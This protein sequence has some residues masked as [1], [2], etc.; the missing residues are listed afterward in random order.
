[1]ATKPRGGITHSL[2]GCA[3]ARLRGA[4]RWLVVAAAVSTAGAAGTMGDAAG[5]PG[6]TR[7]L[8]STSTSWTLLGCHDVAGV[9]DTGAGYATQ[10]GG[11]VQLSPFPAAAH[12]VCAY[13]YSNITD[14]W[15]MQ[16]SPA[17]T[18]RGDS[19][20]GPQS[21]CA[22]Y[23]D[24]G[25]GHRGTAS[26]GADVWPLSSGAD[27][28]YRITGAAGDGLLLSPPVGSSGQVGACGSASGGWLTSLTPAEADALSLGEAASCA[29]G[30]FPA[31]GA[32]TCSAAAALAA[33]Q[34]PGALPSVA[35]GVVDRVV[36]FG[37][38]AGGGSTCTQRR[39]VQVVNCGGFS[40]YRLP[41]TRRCDQSYCTA[42]AAAVS[43]PAQ[44]SAAY[45]VISD[46]WRVGSA[47]SAGR[48]DSSVGPQPYCSSGFSDS[49]VG[50]NAW[51]RVAG[52]AGDGAPLLSLC[53]L[54]GGT[55]ER[56]MTGTT[57]LHSSMRF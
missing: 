40:L 43:T 2:P 8:Q 46:V 56:L 6:R 3:A 4:L 48:G 55:P 1:V 38:V 23:T 44:C 39:E 47:G 28:W 7:R 52:A 49:G 18:G 20:D 37:D 50:G 16:T 24:S 32:D 57:P 15:R 26:A 12:A 10:Q 42:I 54:G 25:I 45:S 19:P 13:S 17:S 31:S 53:C 30:S 41:D 11:G 36:C 33:Y 35:E 29:T 27:S 51:Y 9:T 5:N 14:G 22:S 21:T 34:T